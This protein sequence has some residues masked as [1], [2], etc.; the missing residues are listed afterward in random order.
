MIMA[1]P[2]P[3]TAGCMKGRFLMNVENEWR[4]SGKKLWQKNYD[5]S[6]IITGQSGMRF[7]DPAKKPI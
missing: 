3:V 6:G 4:E 2:E 7:L 5:R 1:L